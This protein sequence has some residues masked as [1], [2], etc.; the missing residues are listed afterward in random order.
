MAKTQLVRIGLFLGIVLL[1]ISAGVALVSL[2]AYYW[3]SG[4]RVGGP[5]PPLPFA[6]YELVDVGVSFWPIGRECVWLVN[7]RDELLTLREGSTI[8]TAWSYATFA[9]GLLL[10]GTAAVLKRCTVL[11][12]NP[13]SQLDQLAK[14]RGQTAV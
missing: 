13:K 1:V 5:W 10:I 6:E 9:I 8:L 11:A 7:E 14:S 12:Q 2:R 4:C 3:Q